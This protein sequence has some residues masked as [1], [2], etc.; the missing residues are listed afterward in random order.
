V[1]LGFVQE[2]IRPETTLFIATGASNVIGVKAD[3]KETF[4]YCLTKGIKILLDCTQ[5]LGYEA[6]DWNRYPVDF[7]VGTGHKTLLGPT[8]IGFV[9][10]KNPED[11]PPY[12]EGGS[13]GNSSIAREH[14]FSMPHKFEAGTMNVVG[15]VGLLGSLEYI[16]E[17]TFAALSAQ[18]MA[19]CEK[20]WRELSQLDNIILYGTHHMEKKIP[21]I[22]FNIRGILPSQIAAECSDRYKICMRAG[23]QCAPLMHEFLQTLP[24]GTVRLSIGHQNTEQE[25]AILL[26]ALRNI[27]NS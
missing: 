6:C 14:P 21:L 9:Y 4:D 19:L 22:S 11:L 18:A 23:I 12:I 8:G 27:G 15:I 5:S 24:T 26:E 17:K 16:V 10:V 25:A 20:L 13:G 3:F 1:D 2:H 7:L